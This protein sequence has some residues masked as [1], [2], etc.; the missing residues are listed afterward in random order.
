[1]MLLMEKY[2]HHSDLTGQLINDMLQGTMISCD[3]AHAYHPNA[4][5]KSDLTNRVM[6][7]K[8]IVIKQAQVSLMQMMPMELRW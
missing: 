5:E 4:P 2:M 3:V 1:M 7:N 6:L 8:G